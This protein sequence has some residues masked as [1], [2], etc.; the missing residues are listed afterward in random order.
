MSDSLSPG[1]GSDGPLSITLGVEV[2]VD[3]CNSGFLLCRALQ[4]DL[5]TLCRLSDGPQ[6]LENEAV[7]YLR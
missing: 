1:L 4:C 6:V 7:L 5:T 2:L 3:D